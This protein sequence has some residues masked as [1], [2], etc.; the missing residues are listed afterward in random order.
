MTPGLWGEL[1]ALSWGTADFAARFSGRALGHR[2]ALFGTLLVGS[3]ALSLW[4]WLA[5]IPL[6]WTPSGLWLLGAAGI[7]TMVATLFLYNGLARGPVSVVSPI[8]GSYP[9]LVV[10]LAVF[11]G[12]RPTAIQ[13]AAMAAT[14]TGVVVVA[15]C[16]GHFAED[17]TRSRDDLRWTVAIA[18]ASSVGFAIA[19]F[20]AQSAVPIY[21][22]LQTLW[23]ARVISLLS[24]L[25]LFL[26]RRE[27]PI[28]PVP[29]WPLVATQGMLDA[30]GYL[31]LYEG[32]YG[33]GS[34]IAAVTASTFGAVTTLLARLILREQMRGL[35][36]I[37]IAVIFGGVAVLSA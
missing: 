29:W 11:T 3:A 16:T 24:L 37:G 9:A 12:A 4:V 15:R 34:E 8:V 7:A 25:V 18:L 22:N 5:D 21:G 1:A 14:L 6:L 2:S 33:S 19:V 23:V 32:S 31:A 17:G 28:V 30:G 27:A 26:G 10:A 20:T 13:W 36:W 35:Q